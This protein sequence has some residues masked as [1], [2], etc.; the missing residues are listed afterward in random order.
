MTIQFGQRRPFEQGT[1]WW[2][3]THATVH[4]LDITLQRGAVSAGRIVDEFGEPVARSADR[5]CAQLQQR[6]PRR[7]T[8]VSGA[9]H[10][11]LGHSGC[12][13]LMP[14]DYVCRR[15]PVS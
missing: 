3:P 9:V 8:A 13:G 2:S 6:R 4:R 12:V 5:R 15:P 7:L 10:D 14:G 11:D 1:P